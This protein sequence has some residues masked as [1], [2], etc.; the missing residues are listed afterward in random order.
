MAAD[1]DT[2]AFY[3]REAV[4]YAD[5]AARG[6]GYDW[7]ERFAARLAP[8]AAVLDLGCGSGWAADIFARRG[9][10]VTAIDASR[11]L[12]AEA[13]RRYGIAVRVMDFAAIDFEAEF[14]GVWAAF[15]LLHA[16]G[17]AMGAH[18]ARIHRALVPGGW[19]YLGLKAGSGEGR[20]RLGRLYS[21][22]GPAQIAGLLTRT[23][24][25]DVEAAI[26]A[27][28]EG[29]DGSPTALLHVMARRPEGG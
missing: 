29:Y 19:L 17:E 2:I 20:D 25:T 7:L 28:D 6:A 16:P 12:A 18:L 8:G 22:W 1:R 3:D 9:F 21:Y 10:P 24:F 27:D 11:G 4:A 15:S 14:G 13:E 5:Y 26:S 23:G